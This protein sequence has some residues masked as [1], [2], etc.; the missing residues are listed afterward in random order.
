MEIEMYLEKI[1]NFIIEKHQELGLNGQ[2]PAFLCSTDLVEQFLGV[3]NLFD[4]RR[5][6]LREFVVKN[7][8]FIMELADMLGETYKYKHPQYKGCM[9]WHSKPKSTI[10]KWMALFSSAMNK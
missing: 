1:H 5:D 7:P 3:I 8:T 2:L 4:E 9:M 10:E 6:C